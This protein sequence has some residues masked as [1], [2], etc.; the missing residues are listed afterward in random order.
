MLSRSIAL[1][2]LVTGFCLGIQ[3]AQVTE[4]TFR[5]SARLL[6]EEAKKLDV[7]K[8]STQLADLLKVDRVVVETNLLQKKITFSTLATAKLVA[9]KVALQVQAVLDDNSKPDWTETLQN[10]GISLAVAQEHLDNLYSEIV[11]LRLDQ[12]T[13]RKK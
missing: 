8:C 6:D 12:K 7:L 10:S 13:K 1:I 4:K 11:V 2:L 3:A 9:D 5:E